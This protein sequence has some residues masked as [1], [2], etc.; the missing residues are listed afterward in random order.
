MLLFSVSLQDR[1]NFARHL[2]L[3]IKT[4]LSLVDGLRLIEEQTSSSSFRKI[5]RG[6]ID[7]INNGRFLS[8]GLR[9]HSRLFGEFFISVVEIGEK[10]GNLSESLL[11][12]AEELEK[13]KDLHSKVK[14]AL[15]YPAI[16]FFATV[17]ITL[18]LIFFV[19][20]KILPIL[21]D[22][23]V[24][25][26]AT[27]RFLIWL[28]HVVS[29]YGLFIAVGALFLI[30]VINLLLRLPRVRFFFHFLAL[31]VPV[32][33]KITKGVTM[34]DFTRSL[35]LLL[36]SGVTIVDALTI[37]AGGLRN[38]YYEREVKRAIEYV[39]RG[40]Q[41]AEYLHSRKRYFPLMVTNLIRVGEMTGNL[42]QNLL[43]LA[44]FYEREVDEQV[45]NLTSIL[46][47]LLLLIMGLLVGFVA[48]SIILPIYK[49]S[50]PSL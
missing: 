25:L 1:I 49:I 22:L 43:Y 46:E 30:I 26:P 24:E 15:I 37:S 48:I 17:G 10:S 3:T 23:Q 44:E 4:G 9:G 14:A 28:V 39:R 45:K 34:V 38:M 50:T 11:H 35:N 12:L 7:G 21:G 18:F 41:I 32:L 19:L 47:P 20:P 13:K 16:I 5:I 29:A 27:T 8:E 33:S 40:S 2:H 42:E 6:L 36:R 31:Y